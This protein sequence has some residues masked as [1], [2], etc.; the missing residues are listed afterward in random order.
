MNVETKDNIISKETYT[1]HQ[2]LVACRHSSPNQLAFNGLD[3]SLARY[4]VCYLLPLEEMNRP[5]E[6]IPCL[7]EYYLKQGGN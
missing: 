6:M 3:L 5:N 2:L 4:I 7:K 1:K